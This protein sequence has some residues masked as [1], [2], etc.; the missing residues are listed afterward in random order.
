[1]VRLSNDMDSWCWNVENQKEFSVGSV[2]KTLILE[3]GNSFLPNFEWCKWIPLKCNIMA[4]RG[5]LDRLATRVN[6]K[7]RNVNIASVM[8][9]FCD[10]Y[11]E[12]A[13]HLFTACS[14]ASRVWAAISVW[15]KIPP[16]F[17]F[18]FKDL[19]EIHNTCFLG[20]RAKKI[21]LGL[22]I[23]YVWCIWKGRN[24]LFSM[25][26]R[27][28]RKRLLQKLSQGVMF[29]LEIGL[30]NILVGMNG[31][32]IRCICCKCF[33]FVFDLLLVWVGGCF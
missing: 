23:I 33:L 8:C 28:A 14:T 24:E 26:I 27:E 17:A 13:D 18:A 32:I 4:W 30:V 2:K 3:R 9:H 5:N 25:S 7:R 21:M 20:K 11:E 22:M 6:L 15:C 1:M 12:S 16:I 10:E 29:G 31:V 19:L